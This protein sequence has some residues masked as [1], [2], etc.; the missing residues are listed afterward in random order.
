MT[1]PPNNAL[2][3]NRRDESLR[4]TA[5]AGE[6][7]RF[8]D[9]VRVYLCFRAAWLSFGVLDVMKRRFRLTLAFL[10]LTVGYWIFSFVLQFALILLPFAHSGSGIS[11]ST[12]NGI[13]NVHFSGAPGDAVL[14]F[15]TQDGGHGGHNVAIPAR[16]VPISSSSTT[17][18]WA[19]G[20]LQL[21]LVVLF[22]LVSLPI[23]SRLLRYDA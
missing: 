23:L 20:Y 18:A 11:T 13:H 21:F 5:N 9:S 22:A 19:N 6:R 1:T 14:V 4:H 16:D 3:N 2:E 8:I 15:V 7:A 17:M 10:W 12:S